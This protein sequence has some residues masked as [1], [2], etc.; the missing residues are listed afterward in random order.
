M[1]DFIPTSTIL[2]IIFSMGI[3]VLAI[4]IP[5]ILGVM[6]RRKAQKILA[7]GKQGQAVIRQLVDTGMRINDDPRVK[8]LLEVTI[9]GYPPYQIW[10]VV[11]VPMIRLSQVQVGSMVAVMADPTQPG[12]AD[13]LGL[14]LK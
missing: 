10:K 4:A 1:F 5:I 7:T 13:M 11:T 3:T 8:V 9:P 14:L 2:I 6:N 12:N